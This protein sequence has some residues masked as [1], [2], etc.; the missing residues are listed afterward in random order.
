[1]GK[2]KIWILI[3]FISI[4][5]LFIP[6]A[7]SSQQTPTQA[8][9]WIDVPVDGLEVPEN[10][11]VQIEGHAAHRDGV[12]HVELYANEVQLV[13]LESLEQ[14]GGLARFD[15]Q[16]L[17]SAAGEYLIQAIAFDKSGIS[18]EADQA[19]VIVGAVTS[20][21]PDAEESIEPIEEITPI[22][23][24]DVVINF[25]AEPAEISA[26][27]CTTL[28][29][30]VENVSRVVF[31][32]AEQ[33]FDGSYRAC[34]CESERYSLTVTL[35][36]G[37]EEVRQ[38]TVNVTGTCEVP[39]P[40]EEPPPA[41]DTTAPPI[42]TRVVPA[43][44]LEMSCK[45]YQILNWLPATDPSGIDGYDIQVQRHSGDDNWADVSGSVFRVTTG[46]SKEIS[47]ECGWDY[48]WRI[49]VED[50]AGNSSAWSGWWTFIVTLG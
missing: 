31:G 39:E 9:A 19:R 45:S 30:H 18:G 14:D 41:V 46:K 24:I 26:D 2:N 12:H 43:N 27:D 10:S 13:V 5:I 3:I 25:W 8:Y 1:M 37:T 23:P 22:T 6:A 11:I 28:N 50:G 47:V 44:G 42:P 15:Y 33:P 38:L 32:G 48:R 36:D 35:N 4:F 17:P 29:W 20:P 21:P 7:C 34:L 16:W 40:E 49:R